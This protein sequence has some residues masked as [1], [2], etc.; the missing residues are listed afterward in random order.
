M[1]TAKVLIP[2]ADYGHDPTETAIP[3][4]S[5]KKAGFEV[6]FATENGKA[7]QCDK[8]MLEGITQKLLG[9]NRTAVD[10][11]TQMSSTPKFQ[12]P[13][14]W[15]APDFTLSTYNL[16]FLPGGHEK[17]V[18]QLIDS[19]IIHQQLASYFPSTIK[20][21]NKTV[22]AVRKRLD[23]PE[24]QYKNSLSTTPFIVQDEKYNYL[25]ARFPPDAQ[26]LADRVVALV[27]KK[28]YIIYLDFLRD[29]LIFSETTGMGGWG[30]HCD[31]MKSLK[32]FFARLFQ[33]F[34][35][36]RSTR[37]SDIEQSIIP[38]PAVR[39]VHATDASQ[40][41]ADTTSTLRVGLQNET[42]SSTVYAYIT[43]QAVNNNNALVLL[44]ADGKTPYYPTSP[45]A[46]G[47]ALAVNCAIPLGAPG[48]TTTVTIPQIAGG[49]IWFSIGSPLTFLLNPGPGLVEPSVSNTSDPNYTKTW[50]FCEFTFNSAQLFI[51]ISY[52]DFVCIPIALTVTDTS[53][54]TQHVSGLPAN[55]FA[56]VCA[57]L[58]AQNA[59]DGA[60]WDQL[61]VQSG[62][63]DLRA[64]SPNTGIIMNSSLFSTYYTTYVKSVFAKYASTA[65]TVDTQAQW[66]TVSGTVSS[67][68]LSFP[69]V[70]T[71]SQPAAKDI[72]SCSTGPFAASTTNTDEMGNIA[73]R[74]AA[75]F[76]RS[77]LLLDS[78]QPDDETVSSYYSTS[79]TN[80]YARILH[81]TNLDG[82]GYAFP[83]DDVGPSSGADQSGS[84]SDGSPALLTVAVGGTGAYA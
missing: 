58:R 83:Y 38:S 77:T 70:G 53:G 2:M 74:L 55:G 42:T 35:L 36:R 18:R 41:H 81:E 14:S 68:V 17:G 64:L 11:Y 13:L 12:K 43:G 37:A 76:N 79:P 46:D 23:N 44:E 75:A 10:A 4:A 28:D 9:A 60:G 32:T 40:L 78:A 59:A 52:V 82:R 21:S 51:N 84:I 61:I 50:D 20:P 62:G 33:K 48:S 66:G 54:T 5:F 49:R 27:K 3:Y 45:S 67:S 24:K 72:F 63:A 29:V 16:V 47:T 39:C 73:A 34:S 65:L 71:F 30:I 80:H 19:P 22:A 26:L 6:D 56:T 69:S 31:I 25:S 7:P 15:S 8:R 1:T 57:A